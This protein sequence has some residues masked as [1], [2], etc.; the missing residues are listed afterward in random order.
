MMIHCSARKSGFIAALLLAA[1]PAPAAQPAADGFATF[2]EPSTPC[3]VS[4][5]D[6]KKQRPFSG[7]KHK[8]PAGSRE[9]RVVSNIYGAWGGHALIRHEFQS[10]KNYRVA[11]RVDDAQRTWKAWLED[12][13]TG[14]VVAEAIHLR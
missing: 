10:G 8:I 13:D 12:S 4:R 2:V 9:L 3:F 11:C 7:S 5:V 6:G 14:A 1:G